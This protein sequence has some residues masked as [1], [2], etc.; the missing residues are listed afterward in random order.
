MEDFIHKPSYLTLNEQLA[1]LEE[2]REV[3]PS[4]YQPVLKSGNKMSIKMNCMGWHW[5]AIDYKYHK[6]RTEID[7]LPCAPIPSLLQGIAMRALL[8]TG[9][10]PRNEVRPFDIC[11]ANIYKE[12][13]SKLGIHTDNSESP[14]ALASGYPVVSFSIGASC[15]FLM[16]GLDRKDPYESYTLGSGDLV[17]FG[18]SKRLAYHGVK[19]VFAGTTP[20][21]LKMKAP[22][23]I[24]LTFRIL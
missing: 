19:K 21:N 24:N 5:S 13:E 11:I 18:R 22:A 20:A 6:E 17:I 8:Q 9:Y 16:G 12:E 1:I 10:M 7:N 15:E 14:E 3:R 23:R 4:F 2:L